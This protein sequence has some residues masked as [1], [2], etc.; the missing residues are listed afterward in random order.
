MDNSISSLTNA[1][2]STAVMVTQK[3]DVASIFSDIKTFEDACKI[4]NLICHAK[5]VPEDYRGEAGMPNVV[6]AL[7]MSNRIGATVFSVMQNMYIVN[8]RPSWSSTFI[9]SA[10]NASGNFSPLRYKLEGEG[11]NRQCIAWATDK[12]GKPLESPAVSIAMAKK[13]GWYGRK[14]SKWQ[15]M[16]ELMLRYRAAAMFG[17]LYAPEI[18]MGMRT[19]EESLDI[20]GVGAGKDANHDI[21]AQVVDELKAKELYSDDR[22]EKSLPRWVQR[23]NEKRD[24]GVSSTILVEQFISSAVSKNIILSEGQ[25]QRLLEAVTNE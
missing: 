11:D 24:G 8:G 9:I 6:I 19:A 5:F 4:A 21:Q 1:D 2:M 18:L 22:F 12:T 3:H 23:I 16:P 15:S 7:E 13:E 17:R 10:I 25:K 20:G 14:G